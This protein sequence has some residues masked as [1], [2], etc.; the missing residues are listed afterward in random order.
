[1]S[2]QLLKE[3]MCRS[4]TLTCEEEL[5]LASHLVAHDEESSWWA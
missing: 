2:S 5:R 3:L 4:E 1:M